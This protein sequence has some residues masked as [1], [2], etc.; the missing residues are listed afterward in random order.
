[1]FAGDDTTDE[2]GFAVV[3]PR[4]GIAIKVGTGPTQALHRLDSPR[5]VYEW[6]VAA[7][8]LLQTPP[9]DAVGNS[10]AGTADGGAA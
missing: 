3:Q 1:M 8:D 4:G 2:T 6:L 9:S 5:A 10:N 7:R